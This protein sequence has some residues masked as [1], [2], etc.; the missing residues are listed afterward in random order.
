MA[1]RPT[2]GLRELLLGLL[3]MTNLRDQKHITKNVMAPPSNHKA[4]F[5]VNLG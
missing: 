3:L 4:N 2:L 5:K 1:R